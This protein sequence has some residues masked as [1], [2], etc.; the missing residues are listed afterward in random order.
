MVSI[1]ANK[2]D[3]SPLLTIPIS[4][5]Y[6]Y[7]LFITSLTLLQ[8]KSGFEKEMRITTKDFVTVRSKL[9]TTRMKEINLKNKR[10]LFLF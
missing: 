7:K 8:K 1:I 6:H 3:Q 5:I 2:R 9:E 4:I 10:F